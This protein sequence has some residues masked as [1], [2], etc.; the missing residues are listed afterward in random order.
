[1]TTSIGIKEGTKLLGK[2]PA[3]ASFMIVITDGRSTSISDTR[4]AANAARDA[5][6]VVFAVGV[7]E[8]ACP[9]P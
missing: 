6:I 3:R 4:K 5:G 2:N 1:T 8:L 9:W 7:G